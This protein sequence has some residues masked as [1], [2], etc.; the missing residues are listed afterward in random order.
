M[1]TETKISLAQFLALPETNQIT[2]LIDGEVV[3]TPPKDEHQATTGSTYFGLRQLVKSGT[4]RIAPTGLHL[5]DQ[6]FV[7]P[8]IFWVED[9][10]RVCQL[11]DDG[12][13]HGAPD[14]IIEI[15][16]PSTARRDRDDKFRLYQKSCVR[17]YWL[18]EPLAE[19]VE[20]Y[21]LRDGKFERQGL[22]GLGETF[23]SPVLSGM[24]LTVDALLKN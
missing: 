23:V 3:V 7:E 17:E 24:T 5:D 13:W 15:L 18:I 20:I 19:F 4:F 9:G 21:C 12:Y 10:N 6:N 8:D 22:Y 16:S 11:G 14:L 2:E 1:V